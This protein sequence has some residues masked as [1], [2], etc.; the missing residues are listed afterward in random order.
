M[1]TEKEGGVALA[2]DSD[3]FY[4]V[5]INESGYLIVERTDANGAIDGVWDELASYSVKEEP[6][7]VVYDASLAVGDTAVLAAA[8]RCPNEDGEGGYVVYIIVD[9]NSG[10]IIASGSISMN[11]DTYA[12][13]YGYLSVAT[14]GTSFIIVYNN[15]PYMDYVIVDSSGD[16]VAEGRLGEYGDTQQP[17]VASNGTHYLIVLSYKYDPDYSDY[18]ISGAL[19]TC[20]GDVVKTFDIASDPS[21]S[22]VRPDIAYGEYQGEAKWFVVY[23]AKVG[24]SYY[25]FLSILSTG[26]LSIEHTIQLSTTSN[27]YIWPHIAAVTKD[28]GKRYSGLYAVTVWH[29]GSKLKYATISSNGTVVDEGIALN[30]TGRYWVTYDIVDPSGYLIIAGLDEAGVVLTDVVLYYVEVGITLAPASPTTPAMVGGTIYWE[31]QNSSQTLVLIAIAI[32]LASTIVLKLK[33]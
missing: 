26:D 4:R 10:D 2:S 13:T 23:R 30:A 21:S 16:T 9:K 3:Y 33:R 11:L 18:N 19:V 27:R 15:D 31:R 14:N 8:V 6:D 25:P 7:D 29:E 20:D 24:G 22:E 5:Y 1:P 12:G 32:I 17:S 28:P